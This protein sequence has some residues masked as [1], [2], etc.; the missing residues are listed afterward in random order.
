MTLLFFFDIFM[1]SGLKRP[2]VLIIFLY[3][4]KSQFLL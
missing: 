3:T 2:I 1:G 4:L